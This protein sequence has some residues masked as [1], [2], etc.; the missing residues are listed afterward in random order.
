MRGQ[1]TINILLASLIMVFFSAN[2]NRRLDAK[3]KH[4]H[5][6]HGNL[7]SRLKDGF[8]QLADENSTLGKPSPLVEPVMAPYSDNF[9]LLPGFCYTIG[10]FSAT[11]PGDSNWDFDADGADLQEFLFD[12]GGLGLGVFAANFGKINCP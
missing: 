6:Y 8:S 4:H 10:S 11:C 12:S 5:H 2:D 3:R 1:A 9:G 7:R